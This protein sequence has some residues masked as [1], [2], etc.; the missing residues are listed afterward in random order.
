M[1]TTIATVFLF[2]CIML[3]KAVEACVVRF[4]S[5]RRFIKVINRREMTA[6]F[7][8]GIV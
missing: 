7:L 5:F 6:A 2:Q 8:D 3:L 1:K 4:A